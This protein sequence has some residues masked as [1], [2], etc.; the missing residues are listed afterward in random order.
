MK[1]QEQLDLLRRRLEEVNAA[2][3]AE[4]WRFT[5]CA[6]ATPPRGELYDERSVLEMAVYGNS[7]GRRF[8]T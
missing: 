2:I 1:E 7:L 8:L 5:R 6:R 4:Y 3:D